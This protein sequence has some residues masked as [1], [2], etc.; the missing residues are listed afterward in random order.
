MP[1][2]RTVGLKSPDD[3][4]LMP[5]EE[6]LRLVG[7][8]LTAVDHD[9]AAYVPLNLDP[10][11]FNYG[12]PQGMLH[13]T[14]IRKLGG[15]SQAPGAKWFK[16]GVTSPDDLDIDLEFF[17]KDCQWRQEVIEFL[18]KFAART[19][20]KGTFYRAALDGAKVQFSGRLTTYRND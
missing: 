10:S 16:V 11:E 4:Y 3:F 12:C 13:V 19:K 6:R 14:A 7:S 17:G 8:V 1:K 5:A 18:R 20:R 2:L 15:H 9:G